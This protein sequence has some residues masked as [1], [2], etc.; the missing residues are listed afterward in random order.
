MQRLPFIGHIANSTTRFNYSWA[1]LPC[2][3]STSGP[4]TERFI[5]GRDGKGNPLDFWLC[6]ACQTIRANPYFDEKSCQQLYQDTQDHWTISLER[7]NEQ[8]QWGKKFA[9]GRSVADVDIF[10]KDHLTKGGPYDLVLLSHVLEHV[11]EPASLIRELQSSLNLD[12]DYSFLIEVPKV[13]ADI[14]MPMW[15]YKLDMFHPWA[16]NTQSL[17][18][19]LDYAHLR[20]IAIDTAFHLRVLA[21]PL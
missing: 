9:F 11:R 12:P 4:D 19:F 16:W 14:S 8:L 2:W 1:T 15:I 20:V 5:S 3:C 7:K 13:K 10:W 18:Y 21:K 6:E 17:L